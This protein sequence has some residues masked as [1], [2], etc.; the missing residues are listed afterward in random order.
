[1]KWDLAGH[2]IC[3]FLWGVH[4]GYKMVLYGD[5]MPAIDV[6]GMK[7]LLERSEAS[8]RMSSLRTLDYDLFQNDD[9]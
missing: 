4:N 7:L 5:E 1:M 2:S 8:L 3:A 9:D 6:I